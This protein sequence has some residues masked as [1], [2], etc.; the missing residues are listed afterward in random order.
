MAPIKHYQQDKRVFS[1]MIEVNRSL[2]M[3][4]GTGEWAGG[5]GKCLEVVGRIVEKVRSG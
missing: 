3:D 5:Y 1:I 4:E 2:Y